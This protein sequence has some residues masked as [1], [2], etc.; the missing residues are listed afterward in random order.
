MKHHIVHCIY[1]KDYQAV[2]MVPIYF[3]MWLQTK[4]HL[5]ETIVEFDEPNG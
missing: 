4:L 5:A 1:A 3:I 2:L